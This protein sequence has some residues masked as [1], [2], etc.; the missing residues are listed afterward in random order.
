[1]RIYL[2]LPSFNLGIEQLLISVAEAK[3]QNGEAVIVEI[4]RPSLYMDVFNAVCT[5]V[6]HPEIHLPTVITEKA[7]SQEAGAPDEKEIEITPQMV[8]AGATVIM[9]ASVGE[10]PL[11]GGRGLAEDVF[12]AMAEE[13]R[14]PK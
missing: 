5:S 1:M 9:L 12:L 6:L 7:I 8:E 10:S 11:D 4:D 2:D 13:S 3:D 14:S